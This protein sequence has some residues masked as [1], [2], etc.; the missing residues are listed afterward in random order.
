[1]AAESKPI[2]PQL[3]EEESKE[4]SKDKGKGKEATI[5]SEDDGDEPEQT[6]D[7]SAG[8]GAGSAAPSTAAKKKK[9]KKKKLKE[10]LTGKKSSSA[11]DDKEA[12]MHKAIDGLT[13]DQVQGLLDLNPAL[14]N[15]IAAANNG[16]TDPN[17]AAEALKTLKL[18]D[19]MT[20]LAASG[21]NAKDMGAYK[22]WSTQPV[23]K[24][25]E[26]TG[27]APF[28]DGPIKV[29][30][31]EDVPTEA[32]PLVAG[33]EWCTVNL[34]K[35]EELLEVTD[36]LEGHYVEDNEA[37][38]RFKYSKS[39][40]NWAMMPPGWKND[41]HVGVRAS[42]SRK[43]VGFI[44]AVPVEL[45]V[46][47]RVIHA[48]EVNFL[49]IHKKLRS[50]RLA[51]VLIKE[52]TRRCNLENVWQAIYTGGTVLP[53]PVSTC[54]YFHRAI[55]WQ[56]L[57]EVGFSPLP[58]NS[59]PQYQ[60]RKYA[61][62]DN[63]SIKGLREMQEKDVDAVHGLLKRYLKRYDMA[64]DWTG[65]DIV[66]WLLHKK[67]KDQLEEQVVWSYVV[68]DEHHNITDF[69]SFYCLESSIISPG[70][71]HKVVRAAY[72]FYYATEVGLTSPVDQ[73][74]LKKR[75]NDLVAD[76]TIL[77]KKYKFDVFNALSLMDNGLFLEDQKFGA[78]DGQ[79]HYYLF[80]YRANP[81][82]GGVDKRNRL[83]DNLSGIGFTML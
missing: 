69:I 80:N 28:E 18:Q 61:V 27:K 13:P 15:E 82:A 44:S 64:P 81:I 79:L 4:E 5:E 68:E 67:K 29:Q 7:G 51:P 63:T 31:V 8:A 58:P 83:D 46:R 6:A 17:A 19:I 2:E 38:F 42:Q 70:S 43:L 41:W 30:K 48:S 60:I 12:E 76:A 40:L 21:K 73:P 72:L 49:C 24:M 65:E 54:R 36:L 74:A 34:E 56:K 10:A 75:L 59:K 33:F 78:G 22:F 9:S 1:M 35:P 16:S 23:M 47:N 26:D 50:K 71:K 20:G 66:H 14:A 39:I 32:A 45:R 25:G 55:N 3:A 11:A 53:T 57:W 62:P 77:A 37:L 52:I